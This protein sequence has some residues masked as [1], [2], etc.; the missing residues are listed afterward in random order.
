MFGTGSYSCKLWF[1]GLLR[2]I[3]S[4]YVMN[5][6]KPS[7]FY[8]NDYLMQYHLMAG[9]GLI[10]CTGFIAWK[11]SDVDIHNTSWFYKYFSDHK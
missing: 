11:K 6:Y 9:N 2:P 7:V 10:Y 5:G 4:R 8:T 3:L 1:T